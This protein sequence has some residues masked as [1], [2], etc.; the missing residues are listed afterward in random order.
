MFAPPNAHAERV[1]L[2]QD[3]FLS[4]Y[5]WAGL[6]L[7]RVQLGTEQGHSCIAGGGGRF[8]RRNGHGEEACVGP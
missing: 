4:A 7:E 2:G 1:Q 8:V 6:V 5:S 3:W